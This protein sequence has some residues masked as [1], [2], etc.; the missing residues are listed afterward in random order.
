MTYDSNAYNTKCN[1]NSC[2]SHAKIYKTWN[3][4]GVV[5]IKFIKAYRFKR[6]INFLCFNMNYK[7]LSLVGSFKFNYYKN[8]L[9]L[10]DYNT[11]SLIK[12]ITFSILYIQRYLYDSFNFIN[13]K[14]YD[15]DYTYYGN[16]VSHHYNGYQF[17]LYV[18]CKNNKQLCVI[19][20]KSFIKVIN[21]K[22][23]YVLLNF[24]IFV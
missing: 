15:Y 12:K 11:K 6:T 17:I 7:F 10:K 24:L 4:H 23:R 2:T 13:V 5:R 18:Q 21:K 1:N 19:T 9:V 3:I 14:L 20:E 16:L 22:F 8:M